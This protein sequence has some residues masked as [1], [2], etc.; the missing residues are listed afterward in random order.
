MIANH[1]HDALAQ[2]KKLQEFI[3]VKRLFK[4]YSG[5]ARLVSGAVA[6][7]GTMLLSSDKIPADSFYHLAGWGAVL[8]AGVL[9]NYA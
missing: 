9:L 1:I 4:G 8:F 2:V 7:V 6:L 5:K 3:L